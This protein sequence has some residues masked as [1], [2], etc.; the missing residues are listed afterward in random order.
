LS[1]KLTLGNTPRSETRKGGKIKR[2]GY[3]T[4][5]YVRY[6]QGVKGKGGL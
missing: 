4:E 3:K 1:E 2:F 5:G 6:K